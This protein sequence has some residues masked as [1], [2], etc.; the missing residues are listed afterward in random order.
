MKS[1]QKFKRGNVVK[2][3]VGRIFSMPGKEPKEMFPEQVGKE[4][5][6]I[7]KEEKQEKYNIKKVYETSLKTQD[8]HSFDKEGG[9]MCF[10]YPLNENEKKEGVKGKRNNKGK[11]KWNLLEFKTLEGLIRVLEWGANK[12]G[13]DNWKKGLPV[14]EVLESGLRHQFEFQSG[15]DIDSETGLHH[16]DH[17]ICNLYFIKW[18]LKNKPECDDRRIV[19]PSRPY[20]I[21]NLPHKFPKEKPTTVEETFRADYETIMNDWYAEKEKK[22]IIDDYDFDIDNDEVIYDLIKNEDTEIKIKLLNL[23]EVSDNFKL[24]MKIPND[25]T[26]TLSSED[27]KSC[28]NIARTTLQGHPISLMQVYEGISLDEDRNLVGE[29]HNVNRAL[30]IEMIIKEALRSHLSNTMDSNS[31]VEVA[32]SLIVKLR[33]LLIK[34]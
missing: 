15:I 21:H 3:L 6:S 31:K 4:A 33:N 13:I 5:M 12:Y 2:V 11:P 8:W 30:G 29:E 19:K 10:H 34:K 9:K 14:T 17:A 16:I 23:G 27:L 1:K 24:F 20:E 7:I 28:V 32:E 25:K 26:Y 18:F 22:A